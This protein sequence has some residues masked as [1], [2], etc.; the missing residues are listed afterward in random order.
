MTPKVAGGAL[1]ELCN[2]CHNCRLQSR[3]PRAQVLANRPAIVKRI[4][5]ALGNKKIAS[6]EISK[7]TF[8]I[9]N[10]IVNFW[11]MRLPTAN[12]PN[13]TGR[14][15]IFCRF[16]YFGILFNQITHRN[17]KKM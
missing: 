4:V 17:L 6:G 12:E 13:P 16:N 11:I 15:T 14:N 3:E 10:P 5:P 8:Y 9:S 7:L 2:E 1:R